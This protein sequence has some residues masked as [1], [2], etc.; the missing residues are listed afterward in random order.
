[1]NTRSVLTA[2]YR[3]ARTPL[4]ILDA[5]VAPRLAEDSTPRL[6]IDRAIGSFDQVVGRLL[7]DR[8]IAQ[9]GSDRLERSAKLAEAAALDEQ[10]ARTRE[11]AAAVAARGEQKATQQARQAEDRARDGLAEAEQ[12]EREGKRR[13]EAQAKALAAK[14]KKQADARK[15]QREAAIQQGLAQD[16]AKVDNAVDKAQRTAKAKLDDAAQTRAAAADDRA[17][18]DQLSELTA[19]KRRARKQQ[20]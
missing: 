2:P 13:A 14:R 5:T 16:E 17:K 15:Q 8:V 12:T 4:T 7:S 19:A 18:A 10:A 3:L 1:V 9:R 6:L 11:S 20:P